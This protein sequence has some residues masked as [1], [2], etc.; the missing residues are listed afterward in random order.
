MEKMV[1][2]TAGEKITAFLEKNRKLVIS[3]F[4]VVVVFLVA[5]VIA[6]TVVNKTKVNNLAKLDE[7]TYVLTK[8]A[9]SADD[10]ELTAKKSSAM[11]SLKPLLGKGGIVGARANYLAGEIEVLNGNY[12]DALKYYETAASKAKKNYLGSMMVYNAAYC[13]EMIGDM[14]KAVENYKTA[15]ADE[16]FA[17]RAHAQFSVGRIYESMGKNDEAVAAYEE[18][19]NRT[20]NL[21]WAKVAKSRILALEVAGKSSR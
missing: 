18:L 8:D 13:Y 3:V 16:D 5:F 14:D 6:D 21:E 12:A 2:Q 4:I 19:V 20:P 17:L 10:A 11:E 9:L 7:I 1:K 15:S